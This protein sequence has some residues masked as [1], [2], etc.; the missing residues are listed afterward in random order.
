[1]RGSAC[2]LPV[3]T[4]FGLCLC[5]G[6]PPGVIDGAACGISNPG[7]PCWEHWVRDCAC[8]SLVLSTAPC[9]DSSQS[10][11]DCK[12]INKAPGAWL[13]F[14]SIQAPHL[15]YALL[16]NLKA[17]SQIIAE[18][19]GSAP[20][21]C[22]WNTERIKPSHK[23]LHNNIHKCPEKKAGAEIAPGAE[24]AFSVPQCKDPVFTPETHP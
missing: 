22:M 24:G 11:I 4:A 23:N 18:E 10:H 17:A 9:T 13:P 14:L 19:K 16:T 2:L 15:G 7:W 5:L 12:Q 3:C 8:L 6:T 21:L 1:M 20:T